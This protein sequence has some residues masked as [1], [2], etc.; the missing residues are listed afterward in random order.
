MVPVAMAVS[1]IGTV[2]MVQVP[3]DLGS[4]IAET[5]VRQCIPKR[6]PLGY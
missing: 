2:L 3:V 5:S 1:Q 6:I 4:C